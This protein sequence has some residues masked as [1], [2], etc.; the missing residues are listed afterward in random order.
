MTLNAS[1]D[2]VNFTLPDGPWGKR[3]RA[4]FDTN[5]PDVPVLTPV[6][7]ITAVL[8]DAALVNAQ[9]QAASSPVSGDDIYLAGREYLLTSRS[10]VVFERVS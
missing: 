7:S 6:S 9:D 5:K 1:E 2:P 10:V 3:W 4:V 8:P